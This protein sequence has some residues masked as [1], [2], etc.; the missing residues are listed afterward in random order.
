MDKIPLNFIEIDLYNEEHVAALINLL[1]CYMR[2]PMGVRAPMP[3]GLAPK[4]IEGLR[5]YPGYL[6]F[7]VK[8]GER[9]AALAN[10]NKNFS[11]WQARH[12]IN[13]HDFIV[14]PDFRGQGVGRFLLDKIADW[15][16]KNGYCR[17]NL[18]VRRD[19]ESAQKLYQKA[20]FADCTPPMYFWERS[21]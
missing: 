20:G 13:I 18:E 12:L 14:H 11:T 15:G 16:Q 9:Y 4:I 2:D 3:D 10:C 19:N 1:D 21:W 7:L 5:N 6:G 8:A 17:V